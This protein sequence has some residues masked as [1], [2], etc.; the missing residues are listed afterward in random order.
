MESIAGKLSNIV[1]NQNTNLILQGRSIKIQWGNRFIDLIK[2]GKIASSSD[3]ALEEASSIDEVSKNGLYL[4][5][6]EIWLKLGDNKINLSSQTN[7]NFISYIQP[8]TEIT[9]EQKEIALSNIG[10]YYNTIQDVSNVKSGVVF[11]KD[12]GLLYI[13]KDGKLNPISNTASNLQNNH[14]FN[15]EDQIKFNIREIPQLTITKDGIQL[16]NPVVSYDKLNIKQVVKT[17]NIITNVGLTKQLVD[18]FLPIGTVILYKTQFTEDG[19]ITN[20]PIP[21]GW[22]VCDFTEDL[23]FDKSYTDSVTKEDGTVEEVTHTTTTVLK[24]IM[25]MKNFNDYE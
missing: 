24:Y 9:P 16:V 11:I 25:K 2:D 5:N 13:V 17:D 19:N 18:L 3:I 23:K 7:S 1:G 4:I 6:E 8:Q 15:S 10:L 20:Y 21:Q 22:E 12:T 14:I